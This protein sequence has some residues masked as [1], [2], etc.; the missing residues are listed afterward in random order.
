MLYLQGL[1]FPAEVFNAWEERT[2][3][4]KKN[5]KKNK[6]KQPE[7]PPF[8]PLKRLWNQNRD[9]LKRV[10]KNEGFQDVARQEVLY[11]GW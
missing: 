6:S 8:P 4:V 7:L 3:F 1:M 11:I 10:V 5:T 9:G 2:K